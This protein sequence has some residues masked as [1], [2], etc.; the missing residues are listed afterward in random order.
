[1]PTAD[2]KG[3]LLNDGKRLITG[4]LTGFSPIGPVKFRVGSTAGFTPNPN[5]VNVT[6]P[7]VF[8]G[9]T[10]LI[11][12]RR[13]ADD[14]VRYTMTIP[15]SYGP[16][17]IGNIVLYCAHVDNAPQA[18]VQVILPF[19]V[20]KEK[21]N[22]DLANASPFPTPGNR[23]T[24]NVTIRHSIESEEVTVEVINPEYSQLAYFDTQLEVPAPPLNPWGQFVVHRDTRMETPTLI[25]KRSDG[26]YWGVPFW[27]N[28]RSPKFGV[29][30]GGNTGDNHLGE[31]GSFLWGYF[32]L[33]PNS[34]LK[35]QI[36]GAGYI[37]DN[38]L[39]FTGTVG[40]ESY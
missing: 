21:S 35:G 27:Q 28:F 6:G 34:V 32:Y 23:F 30:D 2:V 36:G 40:G 24:I 14:T 25:T 29:I 4:V 7:L 20:K 9:L 1:M 26:T 33:T 16:F 15:E 22:P 37:Q 10:G 18:L 3:L 39:G 19:Q 8:E 13:I 5:A 38:N 31:P 12:T 11:Q 17:M